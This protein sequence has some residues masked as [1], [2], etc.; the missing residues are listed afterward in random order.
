MVDRI[1]VRMLGAVAGESGIL[2]ASFSATANHTFALPIYL[3]SK[4]AI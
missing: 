1:E 4:A 2:F 3:S